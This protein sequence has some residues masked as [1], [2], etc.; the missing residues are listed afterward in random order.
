MLRAP[1]EKG[2][3][4][5]EECGPVIRGSVLGA[6]WR[7]PN[8]GPRMLS[9]IRN[10]Y[11]SSSP[12]ILGLDSSRCLLGHGVT[13]FLG[14]VF[15]SATCAVFLI[16]RSSYTSL[17]LHLGDF[18]E[19][20]TTCSGYCDAVDTQLDTSWVSESACRGGVE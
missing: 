1:D 10:G 14:S 15:R 3:H 2:P 6:L 5:C 19:R 11:E 12:S 9:G 20:T 18:R 17:C 8:R 13:S 16:R 7:H 4:S